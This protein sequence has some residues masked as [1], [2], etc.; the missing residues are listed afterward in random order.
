[1]DYLC[2]RK[3]L[4]LIIAPQVVVNTV[5]L[6]FLKKKSIKH[7]FSHVYFSSVL[8]IF[9]L[10]TF[11]K[12]S[13]RNI[14]PKRTKDIEAYY[15]SILTSSFYV[16]LL[17]FN[18][19][20][21]YSIKEA[22]SFSYVKIALYII[23]CFGIFFSLLLNQIYKFSF[24]SWGKVDFD[25]I[26]FNLNHPIKDEASSRFYKDFVENYA[27]PTISDSKYIFFFLLITTPFRISYEYNLYCLKRDD[28]EDEKTVELLDDK[29]K[30][31]KVPT[32]HVTLYFLVGMLFIVKMYYTINDFEIFTSN[33]FVTT[34][35]YEKYY[36]DPASVHIQFPEN[37][38]NLIL[39]YLESFENT[40]A[41]RERGGGFKESLIP[42][43]E[44]LF[45]D[46]NNIHFSD[47]DKLGGYGHIPGM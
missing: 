47:S 33:S 38:R 23:C 21:S 37:K 20:L 14:N 34:K 10:I 3:S 11:R 2:D 24:N 26:L 29:E 6:F 13:L 5:K 7:W 25:Q 42:D 17:L 31:D 19:R 16:S 15:D 28:D 45:D 22:L 27:K 30:K 44:T 39:V 40:F 9:F 36:I 1:M 43:L 41:S 35:M 4:L 12:F 46:P 18:F 8:T 32:F